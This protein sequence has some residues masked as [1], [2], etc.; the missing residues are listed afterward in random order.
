MPVLDDHSEETRRVYQAQHERVAGHDR[1]MSRFIEMF[2]P[3]YFGVPADFFRDKKI[4]DAGCG[5]TA[6]LLIALYR[7][8]ARNLHGCD[9]G[10]DFIPAATASMTRQGAPADAVTLQPGSVTELPYA[11]NEFDFVACHGVLV[12]LNSLDEVRKAFSELARVTK[13]GG[14]IYTAYTN[15]GGLF[16]DAIIPALRSYYRTNDDFRRLIDGLKPED[17]AHLVDMSEH[18]MRQHEG[19][20][21]PLAFMKDLLDVDLCVSIQNL[22][23]CPVYLPIDEA[24]I[25]E[26]HAAARCDEVRRLRRYV[27]R[28]NIRKFFSPLHYE[29]DDPLVKIIYGSGSLEF[30]GRK[31]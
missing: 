16:E 7:M 11:D 31:R 5:N 14:L 10:T 12:C 27:K 18:G 1:T 19:S 13:P 6:K 3:E 8:G 25:R 21:L 15:A 17:F 24:M 20:A 30:I 23:Q 9:I 22:I 2:S 28:H 29:F 4:L 26:M